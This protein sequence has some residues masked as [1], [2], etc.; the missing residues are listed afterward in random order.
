MT[1]STDMWVPGGDS[2]FSPSTRSK[3]AAAIAKG[4]QIV[5]P[6][7]SNA[8]CKITQQKREENFKTESRAISTIIWYSG[9]T[10][11][12]RNIIVLIP[13]HAIVQMISSLGTHICN[14]Q[15]VHLAYHHNV[16]TC[17]MQICIGCDHHGANPITCNCTTN[18]STMY[19]HL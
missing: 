7:T 14:M 8:N 11:T 6:S 19:S 15:I 1:T 9:F 13:W 12:I 18:T 2:S 16:L 4:R 10:I 3:L 17:N 5:K